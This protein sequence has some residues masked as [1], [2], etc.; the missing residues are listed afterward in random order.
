MYEIQSKT[1]QRKPR[2]DNLYPFDELKPGQSFTVPI[3]QATK[4]NSIRVAMCKYNQRTK[5][6]LKSAIQ[7]DGSLTVYC[8]DDVELPIVGIDS[9]VDPDDAGTNPTKIEFQSYLKSMFINQS[10]TIRD[11]DRLEQ[12]KRWCDEMDGRF[13][14]LSLEPRVVTITRLPSESEKED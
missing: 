4:F 2:K 14:A 5:R 3:E 13:V 8:P 10:F 7:P 11:C 9:T 12:F 1:P 6:N